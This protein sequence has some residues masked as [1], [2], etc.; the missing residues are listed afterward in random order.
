MRLELEPLRALIDVASC[1]RCELCRA[2]GRESCCRG[3]WVVVGTSM[4]GC[5][6]GMGGGGKEDLECEDE[7]IS[8]RCSAWKD[9]GECI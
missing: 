6:N 2:T 7:R 1:W 9:L 4:C 5:I 3:R 8:E